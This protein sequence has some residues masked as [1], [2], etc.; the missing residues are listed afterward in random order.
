[1]HDRQQA[2]LV[3]QAFELAL[4]APCA[5]VYLAAAGPGEILLGLFCKL[6]WDSRVA[7]HGPQTGQEVDRSSG[8]EAAF[9]RACREGTENSATVAAALAALDPEYI[10]EDMSLPVDKVIKDRPLPL[11]DILLTG[12]ARTLFAALGNWQ[13]VRPAEPT[14]NMSTS[15]VERI[16]APNTG[17][18]RVI[19]YSVLLDGFGV[20]HP[21]LFL[22][23]NVRY[24]LFTDKQNFVAEGWEVVPFDTHELSPQLASCLPKILPHRYLPEHEI[25][26]FLDLG[27]TPAETAVTSFARDALQGY[28]LAAYPQSRHDCTY[29]EIA[30]SIERA[31]ICSKRG[32]AL[33]LELRRSNFPKSWGLLN[34]D[35]VVRRNSALM[36]RVNEIWFYR[37]V[38][39]IGPDA[40]S[41]MPVLWHASI[42]YKVI[43]NATEPS[44]SPH[45]VPRINSVSLGSR[46]HLDAKKLNEKF[47]FLKRRDPAELVASLDDA[48]NAMDRGKGKLPAVASMPMHAAVDSIVWLDL[49]NRPEAQACRYKLSSMLFPEATPFRSERPLKLAYI[50]SAPIPTEAANNVHVMKMCS[51]LAETDTDIILYAER[52]AE[53]TSDGFD[54]LLERFGTRTPFP[55]VLLEKNEAQGVNLFY[56]LV[57]QAISDGCTHIYTRSLE[58]AVFAALADVPIFFEEHKISSEAQ[59]PY[60]IFLTRSPSLERIIV[61]SMPLLRAMCSL[62]R[63]IETKITVLSDAADPPPVSL[64]PF[65]FGQKSDN[66]IRVGYVGHLYS[67]KGAELCLELARRMPELEFHLLGGLPEDVAQWQEKAR[68]LPNCILHGHRSQKQVRDFIEAVDICIAPFLRRVLAHGGEHNVADVFSPLKIFEYMSHGKPIVAS[69]LPVLHEVLADNET[70]LLCDPDRPESFVAA[71][72]RL[73]AEPKLGQ[74]LGAAA[75]ARFDTDF[76]WT[77]RVQ[78]IRE[79]IAEP[80]TRID[81][82]VPVRAYADSARANTKK[83]LVRWYYGSENHTGWAYGINAKRLSTR[84]GSCHH[85]APGSSISLENPED[86]ALAFD[87]LIMGKKSFAPPDAARRI[88][89][90]GGPTPLKL[91]SGGNQAR[92][93]ELLTEVDAVIALSPQLRDDL[94]DLHP[95]V[96]FIP[97]GIDLDTFHPRLRS[98][99]GR[100]QF[101]V[102]VAASMENDAQRL[103]KGYQ[104]AIDACAEAG[105][106]LLMIGRG[107]KQVPHE[108]LVED[109]Y[110][111]IDVLMH[112]VDAGKEASSNVIMEALALGVPVITTRHAGFHGVA[113]KHGLEALIMRRTVGDFVE[114]I[115]ALQADKDLRDTLSLNGRAFAERHHGLD[116][117][118]Q[119]YEDVIWECLGGVSDFRNANAL[120]RTSAKET[121]GSEVPATSADLGRDSEDKEVTKLVKR[122]EAGASENSDLRRLVEVFA[123]H[124]IVEGHDRNLPI[125]QRASELGYFK[126]PARLR[127]RISGQRVLDVGCGSGTH[128][129]GFTAF[130]AES[131]LGLDPGLKLN[132]DETKD[133]LASKLRGGQTPKTDFGWTPAQIA[134]AI[135]RIK[136]FQGTFE[137]LEAG[138]HLT[139]FDVIILLNVTEHLLE[140]EHVFKGCASHLAP[141]GI[142]VFNHDNFYSW[143]GHHMSPKDPKFFEPDNPEH[144]L[145][146]DWNHLSFDPPLGHY[147]LHGLNRIRLDALKALTETYFAIETWEEK[148]KDFGRLTDDIL[149]RHPEYSRRELE[150]SN[151]VCIARSLQ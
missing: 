6:L 100:A 92:L 10:S 50:A 70:A 128:S 68:N 135:P 37:F 64:Q 104:L 129:L 20:V 112:P 126:W 124:L 113:L 67:G 61:I 55:V 25:S 32:Q 11:P 22:D 23:R 88:L 84:I 13:A 58:A 15:V 98:P 138:G 54:A 94:S 136:Y 110:S 137:T 90:V 144:Q 121:H 115:R 140:I 30:L 122:V 85:I 3:S 148:V 19:V 146:V 142:L 52:A 107:I 57:R 27:L 76:T 151:V 46:N 35:L 29:D 143:K 99:Y 48:T 108:L 74:R 93:A 134:D 116:T 119:E 132:V 149:N 75:R 150:V 101:T 51:A 79:L 145:Y 103:T 59:S 40:V 95:R 139:E 39:N 17:G 33:A 24:L 83:P 109:F 105:V 66:R 89:R 65:D 127:S 117:V 111:R 2:E 44:L 47:Q 43:E 49:M 1:M 16:G 118:A 125:F 96:R 26:V 133:K 120:I 77:K 60:Q 91:A 130:G 80:R 9:V 42:P 131:Y 45:V 141:G 63:G 78:K 34:T 147:F 62:S 81:R 53:Y 14:N 82:P 31:I 69:N 102:G 56:R 28:D 8:W 21:P 71:L 12:A 4:E 86:V 18:D 5:A 38:N 7:V 41:L 87:I 114:A 36:R 72:K 73:T 97:N 106:E 123:P